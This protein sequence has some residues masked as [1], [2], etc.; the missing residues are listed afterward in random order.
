MNRE[1]A[2]TI[3]NE[4]TKSKALIQ[5]GLCVEAAMRHYATLGG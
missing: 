2:W 1:T 5:H 3:L 4:Y